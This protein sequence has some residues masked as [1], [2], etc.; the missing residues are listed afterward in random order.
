MEAL[1]SVVGLGKKEQEGQ[2]PVSG[3]KGEGTAVEPYDS[4]NQGTYAAKSLT[5][6]HADA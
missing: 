6:R 2:E 4:G 5:R 1:K 3:V